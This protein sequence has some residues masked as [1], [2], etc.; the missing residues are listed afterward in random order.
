MDIAMLGPVELRADTGEPV[1]VAGARLR[2]LL[3]LLALDA[4][5]A[6]STG[7][8]ADGV[9]G[10]DQPASAGNALQALVSRLRRA[11]PGLAVA[12]TPAGYRLDLDRDRVDAHRFTR[13]VAEGRC[14][15][16]LALWRG[17]TEFPD[18]ARAE[19][20]RLDELRLAARQ[21][22]IEARLRAG[23]GAELVPELEALVAAHPLHEPLAGLLMRALVAA[24]HPGRAL[25]VFEGIRAEL[26][27]TL[28]ADPSPELSALHVATLRGRQRR[29]RGNLPADVSSFIGREDDLR[30]VSELIDAHRLVTLIGPGGSGKTR[31]SVE[32]GQ[33]LADS[34]PDGVWQVELA[35]VTDPAEVPHTILTALNLRGQV[36]VARPGLGTV[37][38]E[39]VD[40]LTRLTEALAGKELLLILDNCEHLIDAAAAVADAML[41]AAPGLRLLATSREPLGIP[42][43]RLWPVE[44]LAVAPSESQAAGYPAVRLLLDRAAAARPGF[45]LDPHTT[46]PVV[47][48]CRALD[49]MPLA[50]ELAAA[51]L[52][53]LPVDVLA[54]RL[55]DRF[56]LLT[57]GSRT[58]LPRHQT[59]RAV[60]DWS[61]DLLSDDERALW[62]RFSVFHGGADVTA[63]EQ[64][65][66]VELD[67]VGALVD[68]SLLV[69]AGDRYRML[70]TIRE[71]GLERLA[72]A[73]EA[74]RMRVAHAR[75]LLELAGTAEPELRRA[76][77]LTWLRRLGAEHDNLHAA[78]RAAIEAGDTRTATALTAR[79]GWYW[80]LRGHRAEG[81]ALARDVVA[82]TGDTDP[83]DR[84]LT[85]ASAALNGL[86]GAAPF[87]EVQEWFLAAER[88]GAGP[89]SRHPVLRLLRPMATLFQ[90][91]G[92]PPVFAE[93][94]PL[95]EDPDPWLRAIA[96]MIVAHVRLN[97]GQSADLARAELRE[98]L[99]GFRA[100]GERWGIGFSLSALGDMA[101][102]RGD[103]QDAVTWQ[104]EAIA[105]VREVGIREDLPQLETKLAHQLWLAGDHAEAHRLLKQAHET[106]VDIGLPEVLA[107]VEYGY[108]TIARQE[109][110][111]DEARGRIARAEQATE[112]SGHAPQFRAL[113]RSAL[114]LI[115]GAGGD[116]AAAHDLHLSA[117]EVAVDSMDSPVIGYVLVGVADY[118]LRAGEPARAA[119]LLGAAD[120]VRGSV[121][122]SVP[123]TDR[124]Q[125][126]A[127]AELG[128]EGYERAYRSGDAVTPETVLAAT[129]LLRRT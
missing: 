54:D 119:M 125:A 98:A 116:L 46:G 50:I 61:W 59:L 96:K 78:V 27:D 39:S 92:R 110:S 48:I 26:A 80:W 127:R 44:P 128:E 82:M 99:D 75:Y 124:I 19:A 89:D 93:I 74:E 115:E 87:D 67:L 120:A 33:A 11:A 22:R 79:L 3:I 21:D 95:F 57:S 103:F 69:L 63:V 38:S 29:S 66:G 101:A 84:A 13:L 8:L 7:R 43:E 118:A 25:T 64:V 31:L 30:A 105:L 129:G 107:A 94:E 2:T 17:P 15:E 20:V 71:Y 83:E 68:K 9:W 41:R 100:T 117:V 85:Y 106:A 126:A 10:D 16:A 91:A 113:T 62:R 114:A 18:V 34:R 65:C 70:E 6:V 40:P 111:L 35:P 51:R 60:V 73:G 49:G 47:R 14:E 45:R 77:Q 12:A 104:R 108:A 24:G 4:G 97:F 28:G 81:C 55:T 36:L 37:V 109:G 53:T 32:A 5:R 52:R 86:E 122:R 58:A 112:M 121:D 1:P 88:A 90:S 102:S 72:E 123:D 76:D 23:G 42:G 56:R